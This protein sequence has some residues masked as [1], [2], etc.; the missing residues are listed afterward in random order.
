MKNN[1]LTA[2]LIC[3]PILSFA[4]RDLPSDTFRVIKDYQPV[5]IDAEKIRQEAIIDDTL[6]LET[7]LEYKLIDRR[8]E[9]E[10][11]PEQIQAA[12]IK[13][14]P[15]IKLYNGYARVGAG[16]AL[17]PFAE[18]YYNNLRSRKYAVGGHLRYFNMLE[19]NKLK[20]SEMTKADAQVY[21]K[22][23]WK[24][25]TLTTELN[26]G[27]HDFNYYGYYNIDRLTANELPASDLEQQ[28]QRLRFNADLSSTKQDSF[29]LRHHIQLN[30]SMIQNANNDAENL[31][32]YCVIHENFQ[33]N[34][35]QH[36]TK[37]KNK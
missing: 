20:G 6:K 12:R 16:N 26:Y 2:F 15:L 34:S 3:L 29:N 35:V 11:Q 14:E 23:F 8:L 32:H 19:V 5:L 36:K 7:E 1:L 4:Q 25:N 17:A 24:S 21:G 9:V 33:Q 10:Y 30:Y 37:N 28:Y 13:G 18:V 22:R 27:L 31:F